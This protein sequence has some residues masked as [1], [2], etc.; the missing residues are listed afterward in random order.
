M[1]L[2]FVDFIKKGVK[3]LL[4]AVF[5]YNDINYLQRQ[6]VN[7]E[8]V[9]PWGRDFYEY[10]DIFLLSDNLLATKRILGCGDGPSSFNSEAFKLGFD[11]VSVDPI[12]CFFK[13][14]LK[15]RIEESSSH[16]AKEL[17]QNQNDF[18]WSCIKSVDELIKRRLQAMDKFLDDFEDGKKQGR[19]IAEELPRLSFKDESF[20]IVLCSHFLFLYSEHFDLKFHIDSI[21]EM[22]RV[23]SDEV[24][25]FPLLDLKNKRSKHLKPVIDI[26]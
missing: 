19:Y 22:C 23:A 7:L 15:Q 26:L 18:V 24:R 2:K 8:D 4:F 13:D 11:V 9:V 21:L 10:R 25:I 12:Y 6:R 3:C 1:S 5:V 16:I 17:K 14:Q 20:E